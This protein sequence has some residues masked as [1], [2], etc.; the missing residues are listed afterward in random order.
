[1]KRPLKASEMVAVSYM[2]AALPEPQRSRITRDLLHSTA[3]PLN[4]SGSIIRFS[5]EGYQ[6]P[7]ATRRVVSV[8]A[9]ATDRDGAHLNVIL[10]TDALGHLYELEIV[11][12]DKE[13][14]IDPDWSTLKV[15]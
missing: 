10:F 8:D 12:F 2:A 14:T 13:E 5:I 3:E 9:V 15:Y 1:M 7:T 6:P 4:D 11:R